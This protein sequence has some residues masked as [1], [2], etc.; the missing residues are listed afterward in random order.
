MYLEQP[1]RPLQHKISDVKCTLNHGLAI[2][3]CWWSTIPILRDDNLCHFCS[4][5]VTIE[6]EAC[7]VLECP[8]Y[9]SI[10]D[11]LPSQ[12]ENASSYKGHCTHKMRA[13]TMKMYGPLNFT[14]RPYRMK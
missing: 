11:K 5:N 12:Y 10:R 9:N 3:I 14:Q 7:V 1:L 2:G 6:K 4:N 8:I 13:I